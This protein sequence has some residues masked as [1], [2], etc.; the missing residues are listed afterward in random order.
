LPL[1]LILS[2]T[3]IK[4]QPQVFQDSLAQF[5]Y[6]LFGSSVLNKENQATKVQGRQATGFFYKKAAEDLFC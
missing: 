5:S 1:L 4:A 6:L 3:S 2:F